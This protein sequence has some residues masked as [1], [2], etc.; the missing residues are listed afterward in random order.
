[1]NYINMKNYM[2]EN[3][4]ILAILAFFIVL[5]ILSAPVAFKLKFVNNVP[6]ESYLFAGEAVVENEVIKKLS[7]KKSIDIR[8]DPNESI[9][10]A[11]VAI[12]SK[13]ESKKNSE[14]N[15]NLKYQLYTPFNADHSISPH[16]HKKSYDS[17]FLQIINAAHAKHID[18]CPKRKIK[19][20]ATFIDP[21]GNSSAGGCWCEN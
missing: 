1:M 11:I 15:E 21:D 8:L 5:T 20:S 17:S 13:N 2:K 6:V 7:E 10:Y 16:A 9:S 12:K 4:I 18:N 19:C 14:N 3:R